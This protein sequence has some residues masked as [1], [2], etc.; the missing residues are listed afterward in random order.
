[1]GKTYEALKRAEAER[2]ARESREVPS[3]FDVPPGLLQPAHSDRAEPLAAPTAE[4]AITQATSP[5]TAA[6]SATEAVPMPVE[7][8]LP[9]ATSPR[10]PRFGRR[11]ES[12]DN[13][14]A[15][16]NG[17]ANG[18]G[19]GN[20]N[21]HGN[22]HGK[23]NGNGNGHANGNGNGNRYES[24]H[25]GQ[26][27]ARFTFDVP[28]TTLEEFQQL[29]KNLL[30]TR[31]GRSPQLMLM[32]SSRHGEGATTTTALLAATLAQGGRCLVIDANLR[33]P[34][35]SRLLGEGTATG[36][37]EA[38]A[39]T[40]T[41]QSHV[42]PTEIT[43]LYVMPTG[44]GPVRVPYMF[45]GK[46]L[47]D[48]LVH[49]RREFD[50]ILIDGAPIEM[51]ADSSYLAARADGV[52]LV[53]QAETTPVPVPALSLREL[54][55]VGADVLGAVLNRTQSYIPEL[56]T[57]LTNPQDLVEVSIIPHPQAPQ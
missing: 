32:A 23:G 3:D 5:E 45:E 11:S 24:R 34:G 54:E 27:R 28:P 43:N 50:F 42:H 25:N 39:D 37:C 2:R 20:G 47:D 1:M 56:L 31:K 26:G 16:R 51:Y 6:L 40:T 10:W 41:A 49:L 48:L 35:L 21:G 19:N 55:R 18:N 15:N 46:P 29:R 13:S 53:I 33:T 38:L 4:P 22:G 52:I 12:A 7:L 44:V 30:S 8:V 9:K 17:H 14:P 36:L 57:R